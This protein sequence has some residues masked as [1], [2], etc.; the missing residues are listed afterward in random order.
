[1]C[2]NAIIK[3]N[4]FK[5]SKTGQPSLLTQMTDV[6][7]IILMTQVRQSKSTHS[8]LS[9]LEQFKNNKDSLVTKLSSDIELNKQLLQ[10]ASGYKPSYKLKAINNRHQSIDALE[11]RLNLKK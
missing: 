7:I 8:L 9:Q 3:Q 4:I 6:I 5:H 2:F 1:M 11:Q 10:S